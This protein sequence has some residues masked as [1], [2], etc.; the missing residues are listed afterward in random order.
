MN[1]Y[2]TALSFLAF[3]A[4]VVAIILGSL[5]LFYFLFY[6]L[7]KKLNSRFDLDLDLDLPVF[8]YEATFQTGLLSVC[9][10]CSSAVLAAIAKVV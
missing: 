10:G 2:Q 4:F 8:G 3:I 6:F 1:T 5:S 9:A 7:G